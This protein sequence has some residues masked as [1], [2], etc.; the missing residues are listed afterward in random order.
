MYFGFNLWTISS[1]I[2]TLNIWIILIGIY[3]IIIYHLIILEEERFLEKRFG[4]AYSNYKN[5]IRRYL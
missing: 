3:S 5:N 4:I 1:M 2:Y